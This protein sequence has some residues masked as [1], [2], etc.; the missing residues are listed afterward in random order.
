[1]I[2]EIKFTL[3]A[4]GTSDKALVNIIKW[5]LDDLYPEV[6]NKVNFADFKYLKN[7]P[8]QKDIPSR[9]KSALEYYPFDILIYHRDAETNNLQTIESRKKEILKNLANDEDLYKVVFVIPVRMT[10]SWLL[11]DVEAIR[12][13][14]GNRNYKGEIDIPSIYD[15][16]KEP[17]PKELLHR[18]LKEA[19]GNTGR[20][21]K[22]FD[23]HKAVH[24][25]AENINDFSILRNLKAFQRFEK[26]L[27]E[28]LKAKLFS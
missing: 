5:L 17:K 12:K 6:P 22:K 7:P 18:L 21:L 19:S 3:I 1:M 4:D 14:A 25:V 13:A 27:I 11:I 9:I 23:P 26:D 15:I 24:L 20:R 10:E 16:E 2:N 8:L 28:I